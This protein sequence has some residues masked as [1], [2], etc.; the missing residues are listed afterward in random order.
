VAFL[1]MAFCF[2]ALFLL[3]QKGK[4]KKLEQKLCTEAQFLLKHFLH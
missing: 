4:K 1:M 3:T 2:I